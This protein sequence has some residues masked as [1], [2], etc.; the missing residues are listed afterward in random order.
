MSA[1]EIKANFAELASRVDEAGGCLS[2]NMG[3]LRDLIQAGRLDG[4]PIGQIE[5]NLAQADLA[6]TEL[7]RS[8][9]DWTLV[10]ATHSPV[11][12]VIVAAQGG[13]EH[14]HS[15]LREAIRELANSDTDLRSQEREE[16]DGLRA[17]VDQIK[18]LVGPI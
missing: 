11:G 12:R 3:E 7:T 13:E 15:D 4:G 10:Y 6:A 1:K 14:S 17:T 8:Q 2:V 16:L 9:Y 18:A 5:H